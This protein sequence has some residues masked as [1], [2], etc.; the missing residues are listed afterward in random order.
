VENE[1]QQDEVIHDAERR[2]REVER[3]EGVKRQNNRR[4]PQPYGAM[5]MSE[6]KPQDSQ[7]CGS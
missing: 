5:R 3:L 7:V 1:W 2:D 4:W 6:G